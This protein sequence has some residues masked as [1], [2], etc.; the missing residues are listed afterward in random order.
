MEGQISAR[1]DE[2]MNETG[3][4]PWMRLVRGE[5]ALHQEVDALDPGCAASLDREKKHAPLV[6]A[7][8]LIP[9]PGLHIDRRFLSQNQACVLVRS[10]VFPWQQILVADIRVLP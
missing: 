1:N 7:V 4:S 9:V 2:R 8:R 10:V 3:T 6:P 5:C